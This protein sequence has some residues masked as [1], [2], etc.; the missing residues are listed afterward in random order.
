MS[1]E[2]D[3]LEA[4]KTDMDFIGQCVNQIPE[5]KMVL[6][7]PV[8]RTSE[9]LTL[10]KK[11]IG[12]NIHPLTLSFI[13]LILTNRRET[14]LESIIRYFMY[15]Y[16]KEIGIKPA[17]LLTPARLNPALRDKIIR[18]ISQKMNI[19]IELQEQTEPKL[20]GG[21]IMRID[22]YQIDASVASQLAKIK[23]ELT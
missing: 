9:K 18:T 13:N 23:K 8:I 21:F 17:V 19:K 1:R 22:D 6:D 2:K 20:L 15:L 12:E 4:V 16:N 10:F 3:I 7:S 14:N 11:S 5:F